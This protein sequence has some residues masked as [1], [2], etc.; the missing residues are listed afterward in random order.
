MGAAVVDLAS[1]AGRRLALVEQ[2]S[3]CLVQ[4]L[5]QDARTW[6][7]VI[8]SGVAQGLG[9]CQE[10]AQGIPAQVVFFLYLLDVLRGGAAPQRL[11]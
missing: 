4:G 7:V 10:L 9:Q 8:L 3:G 5:S 11:L 1:L 2:G 6:V